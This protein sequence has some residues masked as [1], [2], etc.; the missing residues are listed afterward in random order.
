M[1]LN[2]SFVV[3]EI[4]NY[5]ICSSIIAGDATVFDCL[6][7]YCPGDH[8]VE[9]RAAFQK[10]QSKNRKPISQPKNI[11]YTIFQVSLRCLAVILDF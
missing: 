4:T 10:I 5:K 8:I 1:G 11:G 9:R 2:I 6:G 3:T 7:L